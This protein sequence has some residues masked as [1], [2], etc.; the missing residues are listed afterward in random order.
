MAWMP[1]FLAPEPPTSPEKPAALDL[2]CFS[3]PPPPSTHLS[4]ARPTRRFS[5]PSALPSRRLFSFIYPGQKPRAFRRANTHGRQPRRR[6]GTPTNRAVHLTITTTEFFFPRARLSDENSIKSARKLTTSSICS[7][8]SRCLPAP[9]DRQPSGPAAPVCAAG[10]ARRSVST[11]TAARRAVTARRVCT[12]AICPPSRMPTCMGRPRLVLDRRALLASRFPERAP[13]WRTR[14]LPSRAR[15]H[16]AACR[17]ILR[18][19]LGTSPLSI[20]SGPSLRGLHTWFILWGWASI[21]YH[22]VPHHPILS[23]SRHM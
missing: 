3:H 18:S 13:R 1:S 10:R 4:A 6:A 7:S 15:C 14:A 19:K 21:G 9:F 22:L 23:A 11:R 5:S 20:P 12:S 8:L 17:A 2:V 16:L